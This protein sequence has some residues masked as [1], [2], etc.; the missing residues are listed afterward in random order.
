MKTIKAIKATKH[1]EV[2][3]IKRINERD[4]DSEVRSG[5]WKYIPKSEYKGINRKQETVVTE[6]PQ[7]EQSPAKTKK[8]VKKNS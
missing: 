5:Y 3:E 2:G 6:Q 8:N 7:T 1:V 4:A